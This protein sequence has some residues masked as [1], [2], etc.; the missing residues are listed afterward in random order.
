MNKFAKGL[1]L[2]LVLA[3][4]VAVSANAA[5]AKTVSTQPQKVAMATP[6][7]HHRA[8]HSRHAAK[9]THATQSTMKK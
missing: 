3:T 8:K 4:P 1:L 7:K 9:G 6:K 2:A 5:Q